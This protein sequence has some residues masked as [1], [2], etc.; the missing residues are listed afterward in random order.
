MPTDILLDT[1]NDL[2]FD[3]KD[4][5]LV[6]DSL[7]VVQSFAIRVRFIQT[8]WVFD[9]TVGV[10]WLSDMFATEVSYERKRQWLIETLQKTIGVKRINEFKFTLDPINRGALVEFRAVTVYGPVEGSL[11]L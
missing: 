2:F 3:G 8:E 6:K 10:P 1:D 5:Y 11:S 9:F 7:E 4:F